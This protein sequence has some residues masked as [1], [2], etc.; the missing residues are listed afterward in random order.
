MPAGPDPTD[1][2]AGL[3]RVGDF[4]LLREVGRGG[5]GV[6]YEAEQVSLGRRVALKLLPARMGADAK[7]RGRFEREARAAAKL[8][9]TN[10]VPVFGVGEHE[11]TPY[12]VMQF[13]EGRGLDAVIG[14]LR[15]GP[16][17]A[18]ETEAPAPGPPAD[19]PS[20]RP[21]D[22]AFVR[23]LLNGLLAIDTDAT[24]DADATT[25]RDATSDGDATTARGTGEGPDAAPGPAAVRPP[26]GATAP[27]PSPPASAASVAGRAGTR[28][29]WRAVARVGV[30]VAEALDHA[31]GRGVVHRDIKPS[32][33]LVDAT[34]SVFV[35][36]F[37]LAKSEDGPA[38]TETG[39]VLGTL[40]YMP[41]EAFE[42][43][44]GPRGDLY[45]L[46][47]TLY[48]LA[49]LRPAFDEPDRAGLI[50]AVTAGTPPRL[51]RAEPGVP[52]DLETIVQKAIER[53]PSHRYAS[54]GAL[55]EDLRR[56]LDDRP[57]A[58]RRATGAERLWRWCRRNP[59]PASLAAAFL[60][61]LLI[62]MAATTYYARREALANGELRASASREQERFDLALD[63]IRS[64]REA[65]ADDALLKEKRFEALRSR[66]LGDAGAFYR[67][68]EA[69]VRGRPDR[70]S[71][72]ALA[73]AL[74][75]LG[76]LA[77][78]VE[79]KEEA[80]AVHRRALEIRRGL[81]AGADAGPQDRAALARS[82]QAIGRVCRD[83]GR[84]EEGLAAQG[85]ALEVLRPLAA[86]SPD[87]AQMQ[88]DLERTYDG[89]MHL[90]ADAGRFDEMLAVS[91]EALPLQLRL[92]AARPSDP[93]FK[94]DAAKTHFDR[95]IA[96]GRSG[97]TLARAR[98]SLDAAVAL[99]REALSLDPA[100]PEARQVL[101]TCRHQIALLLEREGRDADAAREYEAAREGLEALVAE[102]PSSYEYRTRLAEALTYHGRFLARTGEAARAAAILDRG[103]ELVE[104]VERTNP[105]SLRTAALFVRLAASRIALLAHAG[106]EE[107]AVALVERA[108]PAM[109]RVASSERGLR[110]HAYALFELEHYGGE[111]YQASL[112]RE[113][114]A[115]L[116]RAILVI[117]RGF[118]PGASREISLAAEYAAI[119]AM[120]GY[121]GAQVWSYDARWAGEA[122]MAAL[123]RAAA[124]GFRD[125]TFL[126][127]SE[128][129]APLRGRPDFQLFLMDLAFPAEPFAG[130]FRRPGP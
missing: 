60:L 81:A 36:D 37:G 88:L 64:T 63:A 69:Q 9:H 95:A 102:Y 24:I 5:M 38:L 106:G 72:A 39:D 98:P 119:L 22:T 84:V 100:H 126:R 66:L 97:E 108:R 111:A 117:E 58:A 40:R 42:G 47:L 19:D 54:A 2:A 14:E 32:N 43:K 129:L 70:R 13:I 110:N 21:P 51:R 52:R 116:R 44:S 1:P 11:G 73:A 75:E 33:L 80:L 59:L 3:D 18:A 68:L 61:A 56:F 83:L 34:G 105:R 90:H 118:E 62:G 46:G 12:Y 109:E 76:E 41:P 8:H 16:E 121:P 4:R 74:F 78:E 6:V 77:S 26:P 86:A 67:R 45:S 65:V 53:D 120:S 25:D 112:P 57:I 71:R 31:H 48:E 15:R 103:L 99:L 20:G 114:V 125:A 27:G 85:R 91:E 130:Q 104:G 92:A 35:A 29:Y 122:A 123:R 113:A 10:I 49:A 79:S 17:A 93:R 124:A 89:L 7:H 101:G 82:E 96:Y 115:S 55:A 28:A 30:Q 127:E 50:R 128:Q 107:A 87:D 94:V 23:S